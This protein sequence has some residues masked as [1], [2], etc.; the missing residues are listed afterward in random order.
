MGVAPDPD[1]AFRPYLR[2]L[3]STLKFWEKLKASFN[4][5]IHGSTSLPLP[6]PPP[7]SDSEP[8]SSN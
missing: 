2:L 5:H 7:P 4:Q 8:N 3:A 6:P 1:E